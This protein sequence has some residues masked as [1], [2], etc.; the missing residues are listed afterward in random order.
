MVLS[1]PMGFNAQNIKIRILETMC[2][3]H[4]W[5]RS[6]TQSHDIL[7]AQSKC[8]TSLRSICLRIVCYTCWCM[9]GSAFILYH[10]IGIRKTN[11]HMWER[12]N[13]NPLPA[14]SQVI[15]KPRLST[16]PARARASRR[17]FTS[18]VDLSEFCVPFARTHAASAF[19][20]CTVHVHA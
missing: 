7:Y 5:M 3:T 19:K 10:S 2:H 4:Q 18:R 9:H 12:Y 15:W 13:R 17:T 1:R 11:N 8:T 6:P 16:R 14:Y 20:H